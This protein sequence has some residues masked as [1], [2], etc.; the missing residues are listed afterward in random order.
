LEKIFE[1]AEVDFS[2]GRDLVDLFE[3]F[4]S[5]F[6]DKVNQLKLVIFAV[7]ASQQLSGAWL[8]VCGLTLQNWLCAVCTVRLLV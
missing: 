2:S 7:S 5:K 3:Q 1:S 8:F 4:V 6:A